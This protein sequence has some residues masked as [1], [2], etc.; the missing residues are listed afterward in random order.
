MENKYERK[1]ASFGKC[2]KNANETKK[3]EE[4]K[5]CFAFEN[6]MRRDYV[7]EKIYEAIRRKCLPVYFGAPEVRKKERENE[8]LKVLKLQIEDFLPF[9]KM[10]VNVLDFE[11][12]EELAK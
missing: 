9:Q 5:F 10:F 7:T 11:G 8:E 3:E 6:I 1:V 4:F 12:P 2:L